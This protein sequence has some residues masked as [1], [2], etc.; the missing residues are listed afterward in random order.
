MFPSFSK[1]PPLRP[2]RFNLNYQDALRYAVGFEWYATKNFTLRLGFAYDETPIPSADFRT[3]RIPD[4][5]K[6]FLSAGFRWSPF[7]FM[8]IDVGYAHLFVPDPQVNVTDRRAQR[9]GT[10]RHR[11][12]HCGCGGHASLGRPERSANRCLNQRAKRPS[13]TGNEC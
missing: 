5:N 1:M 8:D 7:R 6:Y 11:D 3:P 9:P 10:V 2:I 4:N 13:A 12:Q